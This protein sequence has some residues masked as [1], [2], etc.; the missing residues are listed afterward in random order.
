MIKLKI[1]QPGASR[2][3][4]MIEEHQISHQEIKHYDF[5]TGFFVET[6]LGEVAR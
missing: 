6:A 3:R 1:S 2:N 4:V 5:A